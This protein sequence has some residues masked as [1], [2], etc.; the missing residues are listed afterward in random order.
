MG[1][2]SERNWRAVHSET[3]GAAFVVHRECSEKARGIETS[4]DKE[5]DQDEN[6]TYSSDNAADRDKPFDTEVFGGDG[7]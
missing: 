1:R 4:G 7:I 5:E 3:M 2:G 6:K